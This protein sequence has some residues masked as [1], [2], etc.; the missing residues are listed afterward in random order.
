MDK[1]SQLRVLFVG[2]GNSE[3]T[4]L[5]RLVD[6]LAR[7][8]VHVT[9]SSPKRKMIS[10]ISEGKVTWI[11]APSWDGSLIV[12]FLRILLMLMRGLAS[13]RLT[14]LRQI[15]NSRETVRGKLAVLNRYLPFLRGEWDVIYF[16]WNAT[17]I[18]YLGLFDLG[19]PVVI[20]CRGS[21]I[22]I[23]P[24][25]QGQERYVSLLKQTL[26][27]A[28]AVHCVSEDIL[29]NAVVLGL[30]P[31]KAV[32]IHPAVDP[33]FFSPLSSDNPQNRPLKLITIGSLVWN[34]GY[35]YLLM[36]VK[37]LNDCR[38]FSELHIIGKGAELNRIL[39]TA[40]DLDISSQVFLHGKL[41]PAE[42]IQQLQQSDIFVLSSLSEGIS[43]AV[44]EAMSCS[45]PIV[46]TECGGMREAVQDGVQGL[47]V[48]VRDPES[49]AEAVQKLALDP[50]LRKSMGRAGRERVLAEFNSQTQIEAFVNQF[51]SVR[52]NETN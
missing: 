50:D 29:S 38:I 47:V 35:E 11:W 51:E 33:D 26:K 18:S 1:N 41:P 23:R 3:V 37:L 34:K 21:Q 30:D 19:I 16:P 2:L 6:G 28:A 42:V 46:T 31:G 5:N 48:P 39:F 44:L 25:R 27:K 49:M 7:R 45:L 36:A 40:Q 9:I 24:H 20:S 14:W 8:G 52:V 12:R 17:A 13:K 15:F 22:N 10:D 43:N 4:F 32:V